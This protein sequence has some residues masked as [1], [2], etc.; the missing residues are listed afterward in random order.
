MSEQELEIE[1]RRK[2]LATMT[3][4][5]VRALAGMQRIHDLFQAI[6][7]SRSLD[8]KRESEGK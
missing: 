1:R 8:T 2:A 5:E 6:C 4:S 7:G 3:D